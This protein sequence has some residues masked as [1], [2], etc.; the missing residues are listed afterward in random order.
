MVNMVFRAPQVTR[1]R[2]FVVKTINFKA[3]GH[4]HRLFEEPF[5]VLTGE[6]VV[7]CFSIHCRALN[8]L[9]PH[10]KMSKL[11]LF[12]SAHSRFLL[13]SANQ[14]YMNTIFNF[15]CIYSTNS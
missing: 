3:F 4:L 15:I 1:R 8:I 2:V 5:R 6:T 9:L 11:T 14:E 10:K 12:Y 7:I 13:L